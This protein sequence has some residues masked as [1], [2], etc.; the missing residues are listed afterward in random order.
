MEEFVVYGGVELGGAQI[1]YGGCI[2]IVVVGWVNVVLGFF[3]KKL[4]PI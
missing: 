3:A 1:I 2:A 4:L